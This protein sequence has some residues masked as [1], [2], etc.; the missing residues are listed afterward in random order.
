MRRDKMRQQNSPSPQRCD[1]EIS[2]FGFDPLNVHTR[3]ELKHA[4]T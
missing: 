2:T 4:K 1:S 3:K